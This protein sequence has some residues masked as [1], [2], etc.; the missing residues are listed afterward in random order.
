VK[1]ECMDLGPGGYGQQPCDIPATI[2]LI[3]RD[4]GTTRNVC[5]LH[6]PHLI[7]PTRHIDSPPWEVLEGGKS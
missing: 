2:T 6:A 7:K 3:R 4:T 1:C 5:K